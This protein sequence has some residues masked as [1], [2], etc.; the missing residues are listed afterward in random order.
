MPSAASSEMDP[1]GITSTGARV[2]SPSRMIAPLPNCRSI[3][4]SAASRDF[5]L[6]PPP[7]LLP[8]LSFGAMRTPVG[9]QGLS[10]VPA[11]ADRASEPFVS[12]LAHCRANVVYCRLRRY[13]QPLT[14]SGADASPGPARPRRTASSATLDEQLFDHQH[15]APSQSMRNS[16]P[17]GRP[18]GRSEFGRTKVGRS[19]VGRSEVGLSASFQDSRQPAGFAQSTSG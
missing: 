15:D 11:T 6:S 12:A 3:W 18:A 4:A 7:L 17:P 14:V 16:L 2:S 8:A 10:A 13:A 5:S 19:E 9:N 1:V